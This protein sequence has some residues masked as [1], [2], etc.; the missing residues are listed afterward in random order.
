MSDSGTTTKAD[1]LRA[2]IAAARNR[3]SAIAAE[4]AA[5]RELEDLAVE[6]EAAEQ[7]ARDEAAILA[8]ERQ[9][10]DVLNRETLIGKRLRIAGYRTARGI[11]IVKAPDPVKFRAFQDRAEPAKTEDLISL[12][13]PCRVVPELATFDQIIDTQPGAITGLADLVAYLAGARKS[14][15]AG[16]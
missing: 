14:A 13:A 9:C 2:R 3:T 6:A 7:A 1:E 15:V 8:A 11:V 16:K 5:D 10:G 12:V 4:A